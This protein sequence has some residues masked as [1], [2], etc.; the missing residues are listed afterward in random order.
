M[1][2]S[3]AAY[4]AERFLYSAREENAASNALARSMG[5]ILTG[6]EVRADP[7]DGRQYRMLRYRIILEKKA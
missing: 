1:D 6:S 2:Y 3:R 5:F 7:R 4:G